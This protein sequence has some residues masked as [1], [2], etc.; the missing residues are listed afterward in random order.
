MV[1]KYLLDWDYEGVITKVHHALY[2][3]ACKV[4]WRNS[5][6]TLA[7]IDKPGRQNGGKCMDWLRNASENLP[8]L[9]KSLICIR[10]IRTVLVKFW[11]RHLHLFYKLLQLLGTIPR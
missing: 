8:A 3:V 2:T 9:R 10:V 6:P 5:H 1:N 4:A 7:V 11:K